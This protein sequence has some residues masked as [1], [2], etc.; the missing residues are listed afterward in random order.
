MDKGVPPAPPSAPK[1]PLPVGAWDAHAHLLGG[2]EHPLSPTRVEDPAPGIDLGG[3]LRMYRA[4]LDAL[5]CSKGLIV[6]SILYGTDNTVTLAAVKA[7]GAGFAGVGLLPDGA[8][9]DEIRAFADTNIVAVR[10]NYVHGGVLSWDGAR[11]MAP[12]LADHGLHIQMLLHADQHIADLADDIRA[13]PVPLVIDHCAWPTTLNPNIPAIDTLCALLSEGHVYVKLSAPNRLTHTI[14]AAQPLMR[15]LIS[16]NP[17]QVLWG[18]DWPHIMLGDAH[19]PRAADLADIVMEIAST[20]E[21]QKIFVTN[22][23]RLFA[24][25]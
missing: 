20:D 11:A 2:P 18:S 17:D 12:A 7:M 3:W 23:D 16:A 21:Q 13:L 9:P 14:D 4:H 22:P 5:G 24:P 1:R 6:H 10:L 25:A 19:Q 8:G 15:K